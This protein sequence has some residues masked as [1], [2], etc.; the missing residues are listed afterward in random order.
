M[1]RVPWPRRRAR[2]GR[3]RRGGWLTRPGR[4][5]WSPWSCWTTRQGRQARCPR[6]SR[7]AR[8]SWTRGPTR[9][10]RSLWIRWEGW[11]RRP[12]RSD[13]AGRSPTA[14]LS[15][16][17]GL[18]GGSRGVQVR[19]PHISNSHLPPRHIL[20]EQRLCRIHKGLQARPLAADGANHRDPCSS[21]RRARHK[22]RRGDLLYPW[23]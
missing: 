4:S 16:Q 17:R 23:P 13:G 21:C 5:S 7:P 2:Q 15:L 14:V 12:T 19:R 20:D 22:D 11:Q 1:C 10:S 8:P 9:C 18:E 6:T 3:Q